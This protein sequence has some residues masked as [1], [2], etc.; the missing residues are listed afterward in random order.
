MNQRR[1]RHSSMFLLELMIA[2]LFFCLASAVCI[3]LFVKS[4][5]ISQ[6]TENLNMA[7]N[8]VSMAAEVFQSGMDMETFLQSEFPDY[9][10]NEDGFLIYYNDKWKACKVEDARFQLSIQIT[11]SGTEADGRFSM[12]DMRTNEE[13]YAVSLDK[14]L[15]ED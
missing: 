6:E 2:I 9:G 5:T 3:R 8:Q 4:H 13:I 11:V 7:L 1:T 14:F 10:E 15:W 12:E